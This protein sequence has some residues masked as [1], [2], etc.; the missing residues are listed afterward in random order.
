M[1]V[2]AE[3]IFVLCHF[4]KLVFKSRIAEIAGCFGDMVASSQWYS[5]YY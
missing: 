4:Q 2:F 5:L 1:K 3:A